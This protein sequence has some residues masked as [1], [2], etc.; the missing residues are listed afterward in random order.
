MPL[1]ELLRV[2]LRFGSP[3]R[4]G[5]TVEQ[6]RKPRSKFAKLGISRTKLKLQ[7]AAAPCVRKLPPRTRQYCLP[8]TVMHE[9]VHSATLPD[10]SQI[11][12][13]AVR[14]RCVW[15]LLW[16]VSHGGGRTVAA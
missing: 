6:Q 12:D 4:Q 3:I 9:F 15:P 11:C 1:R 10:M 7:A 16:L 14:Q 13:V 2:G 8:S 5:A